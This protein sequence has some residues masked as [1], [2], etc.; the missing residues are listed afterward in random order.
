[1]NDYITEGITLHS[2]ST[3]YEKSEKS[4]KYLLTLEKHQ[5]SKT[6]VK[7][8]ISRKTEL[9]DYKDILFTIREFYTD[10][11]SCKLA[12][13]V[14]EC[15]EFLDTLDIPSLMPDER[16][17][18]EG[19]INENKCFNCLQS[20]PS[21]KTPG[22]DR[23]TREFDI[24]FFDL[25]KNLFMSSINYSK[26]QP[27]RNSSFLNSLYHFLCENIFHKIRLLRIN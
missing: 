6:F 3:W 17:I 8:L 1:M 26:V 4:T 27:L 20:M 5:K 23:I 11:F 22:N 16:D 24:T 25:I 21:N 14:Q 10:L 19:M 13:T 7:R 12:V 18:C 9:F 2:R 15:E